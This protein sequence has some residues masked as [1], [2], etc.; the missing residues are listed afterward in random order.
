M[1]KSFLEFSQ[2]NKYLQLPIR[3]QRFSRCQ[4]RRHSKNDRALG[5]WGCSS[6]PQ[7]PI[8]EQLW[9]LGCG[10]WGSWQFQAD[11]LVLHVLVC[12][13]DPRMK[14]GTQKPF[15]EREEECFFLRK[16]GEKIKRET[17]GF[18]SAGSRQ[19]CFSR[20]LGL[21]EELQRFSTQESDSY[22]DQLIPRYQY[23]ESFLTGLKRPSLANQR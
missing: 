7:K 23:K 4:L 14:Q 13:S 3:L 11:A 5:F 17:A 22:S 20:R 9:G 8:G 19:P 2:H 6:P 15:Q 18:S 21:P 16:R 12:S 1:V 10:G